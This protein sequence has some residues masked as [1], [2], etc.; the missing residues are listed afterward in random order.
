MT[1]NNTKNTLSAPTS[2][3]SRKSFR[4]TLALSVGA[5]L[6]LSLSLASPG[7]A[8]APRQDIAEGVVATVNDKLIS[9]YDLRQRMLLLIVTSGVQVTQENYAAFQQQALRAL[10]DE[11]L[12]LQ[13]MER[14]EVNISDAEIDDEI[15]RMAAQSGL[16]GEQLLAELQRVGVN[17]QTLRTQIKAEI[18]WGG[19]VSGR[20]RSKARVGKEQ[21]DSYMEK[22]TEDSQKP[23]YLVAEIYIDPTV[24]GGT[25]EA[26]AG[27]NQLFEQIVQGVA[28]F[29]AVARQFSNAPSAANGGDAGWIV[30]GTFDPKIEA[31]L[32][33][34]TEGQMTRPIVTDDGVYIYYLRE[35]TAGNS[36]TKV[37]LKQAAVPLEAQATDRNIETAQK[38]L[39]SFR[40]KYPSC[41][42]LGDEKGSGQVMVQDLGE[43]QISE[44]KPEYA[45]A[46]KPLK[47]G[48]TTEPMRNP[49]NMNVVYVCDKTMAGANAPT[50]DQIEQR[51]TE[52]R[53]A[54][55]GRRYLRDI[56]TTATIETR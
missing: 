38:A 49:M 32:A 56:R 53:V 10:I 50:R 14:W 45:G 47:A 7:A 19:L 54:M 55:L 12:E 9:S 5:C 42:A 2:R 31:V 18:G 37:R 8:Q 15:N 35:K 20:F 46:L 52:E 44:L 41:D 13:E 39:A 51:L 26:E 23:Q 11:H 6:A 25:K 33:T 24:A 3:L 27:A 17:P 28:P 36:D 4:Q 48:Q 34:M 29:Q 30:S 21:V 16:T 43:V 40:E 22:L 1:E